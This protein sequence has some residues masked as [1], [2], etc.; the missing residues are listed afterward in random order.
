MNVSRRTKEI[1]VRKVAGASVGRVM[2]D[3]LSQ[4]VMLVTISCLI[5]SVTGYIVMQ[6]WLSYYIERI[7]LHAGYFLLSGLIALLI[8]LLAVSWQSW[9]AATRNPVEALRYE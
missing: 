3:L 7:S 9:K 5:A 1:G 2:A 6:R 4:T 8:A